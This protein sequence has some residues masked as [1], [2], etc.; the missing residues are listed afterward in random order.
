MSDIDIDFTDLEGDRINRRN[1]LKILSAAGMTSALAGC[2]SDDP[3]PDVANGE[4]DTNDADGDDTASGGE[5]TLRI[6]ELFGEVTTLDHHRCS[7]SICYRTARYMLDGLVD[8]DTGLEVHGVLAE[9]W[10]IP[11]D[12]TVVFNIREGVEWHNG[13]P[14]TAHDMVYSFER[15]YMDDFPGLYTDELSAVNEVIADDDYTVRYELDRPY[16]PLFIYLAP[17]G[18]AGL[19][20]NQTVAEEHGQEQYC[21]SA[22]SAIGNGAFELVDWQPR[23]KLTFEANDDYWGDGPIVDT[24]EVHLIE[25]DN[26]LVNALIT[27]EVDLAP[28]V[29]STQLEVL[30]A[31]PEVDVITELTGN[32]HYIAFNMQEEPFTDQRVRQAIGKAIDRERIVDDVFQG[33]AVPNGYPLSPA[34]EWAYPGEPGEGGQQYD[35]ERAR[36]LLAEAGYPD[37]FEVTMLVTTVSP[38]RSA[39]EWL[40]QELR[41]ELNIDLEVELLEWATFREHTA[42]EPFEFEMFNLQWVG[43]IDPDQ[44]VRMF[45]SESAVNRQ[46][47]DNPDVDEL[48]DAQ[49]SEL[50]EEARGEIIKELMEELADYANYA[51]FATQERAFGIRD[52]VENFVSHPA[53]YVNV[54][55]ID[56]S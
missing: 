54:A 53:M 47:M 14:F 45:H 50:N 48:I 19:P 43:D 41:E 2:S 15:L 24:V 12:T 34:F 28:E 9:D 11:D 3:D 35:P 6:G 29:P 25:N 38:W 32:Y 10:E 8:V 22:E 37:G 31:E 56:I 18:R 4:A 7:N 1:T 51:P 39:G 55:D 42:S 27:D 46:Y 20:V 52:G 40:A 33:Y 30:E 5:K 21:D 16:A 23:E 44:H 17:Q 49:R 13:E 26:A 36:E